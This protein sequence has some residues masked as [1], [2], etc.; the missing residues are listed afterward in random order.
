MS[1]C[2]GGTRGSGVLSCAG[3]V[4]KM[5]VVIGVGGVCDMCMCLARGGVGSVGERIGCGFYQSWMNR[6]KE[7]YVSGCGGVGAVEG[8]GG[9]L[10]QGLR[11][12]GG[13]KS[14]FVVSLFNPVAP[15]GYLLPNMYL[16]IADITNPHSFV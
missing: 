12:W 13:V 8:E 14:V 16:F 7:G 1:A 4:F 15:Y 9:G 5:S 2:I 10:V 6:G 3:N 11:G